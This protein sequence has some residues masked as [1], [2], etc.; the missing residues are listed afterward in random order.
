LKNRSTS[1]TWTLFSPRS[2][3]SAQVVAVL[4]LRIAVAVVATTW[5]SMKTKTATAEAVPAAVA[6]M[7]VA[8]A[9]ETNVAPMIVGRQPE[10]PLLLLARTAVVLR[11]LV[12][13]TVEKRPSAAQS[14][15]RMLLVVLNLVAMKVP[16]PVARKHRRVNPAVAR[17]A[18]TLRRANL[19]VRN[20]QLV[21]PVARKHQHD[22]MNQPENLVELN[23]LA[24]TIVALTMTFHLQPALTTRETNRSKKNR[25]VVAAPMMRMLL[26]RLFHVTMGVALHRLHQRQVAAV[27]KRLR[28][29]TFHPAT[30]IRS[31]QLNQKQEKWLRLPLQRRPRSQ[32]SSRNWALPSVIASR[33][34]K[35]KPNRGTQFL[36]R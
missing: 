13:T 16:S 30:K 33:A 32:S 26:H 14:V 35:P 25:A 8:P 11:H 15:V 31:H 20:H 22:A 1:A 18:K 21:S 12:Q 2:K 7:T 23:R 6:E 28:K 3:T 17:N 24:V 4:A 5:M 34:T 29:K 36:T 9:A 27:V 19:A 10:M